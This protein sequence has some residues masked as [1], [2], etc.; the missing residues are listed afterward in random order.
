MKKEAYTLLEFLVGFSTLPDVKQR[1]SYD[2]RY[3]TGVLR[4]GFPFIFQSSPR[5]VFLSKNKQT[6]KKFLFLVTRSE[7]L[8][9]FLLTSCIDRRI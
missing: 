5:E 6:T 9:N 1:R 2:M 7:S 8:V 3:N 4:M